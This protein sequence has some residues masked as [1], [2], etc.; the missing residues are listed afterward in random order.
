MRLSAGEEFCGI[1]NFSF[2]NGENITYT[3]FY[4][5]IGMYVNAGTAVFSVNTEK[6][7]NKEAYHLTA[8]GN[9]NPRYDWIFKVRD[10]YES[11]IDTANLQPLKFIRNADEGG[12]KTFENVTFNQ[13][14]NTATCEK[15]IIKV[16]TCVQDVL[17]TIY[18][19]RNINF[20]K[21]KVDDKIPFEMYL[22]NQVY[23]LFIRYQ[24]K[25]EIKTRYGRFRTIKFKPLLLKG[26]I[27][28]GG[29]KMSVWLSDDG[30]HIPLRIESPIAVGS[31]KVDMMDYK[32]LRYPLTSLIERK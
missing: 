11:F 23:S 30:N 27:F 21:Y 14:N 1:R 4:S 29:E 19:A 13:Q 8:T 25:E 28:A 5:V 6:I 22:D 15:G 9:S 12:Y 10:K 2:Q 26:N 17:S 24:G 32:N 31:V 20:N 16:P 7:N 3:I 18:F